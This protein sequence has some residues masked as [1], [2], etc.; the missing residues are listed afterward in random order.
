MIL[1]SIRT[2]EV[3]DVAEFVYTFGVEKLFKELNKTSI[4]N[5][6]DDS[7][8]WDADSVYID[9]MLERMDGFFHYEYIHIDSGYFIVTEFEL[10]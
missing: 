6:L 9:E 10:P 7:R 8:Q 2:E 1:E 4:D 3:R 5:W